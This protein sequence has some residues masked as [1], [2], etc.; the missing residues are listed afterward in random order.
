MASRGSISS[1]WSSTPLPPISCYNEIVGVRLIFCSLGLGLV[2][3][4]LLIAVVAI[5][6]ATAGGLLSA[7]WAIP[8]WATDAAGVLV[9]LLVQVFI[10]VVAFSAIAIGN[11]RAQFFFPIQQYKFLIRDVTTVQ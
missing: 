7:A 9:I 10:M 4:L 1:R 3:M 2:A 5:R 6:L 11:R 8:G